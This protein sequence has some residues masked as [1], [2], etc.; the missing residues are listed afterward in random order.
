MFQFATPWVLWALVL[1]PLVI[2]WPRRR[3]AR[4]A[5]RYSSR[6]RAS[7]V[8][9][10]LRSRLLWLVP[11]LRAAGLILLIVAAARPRQGIGEVRTSAEGVAIMFVVDRSW[12]MVEPIEGRGSPMRI[13]VVKE[14][15]KRF[16]QGD[17]QGLDGRSNDL[18]GLVTF[19]KYAQTVCPLVRIHDSLVKLVDSIEL[20][21]P[22][23]MDAGTAIGE[24]LALAAARLKDAEKDL[25]ERNEGDLDPDFTLKSKVIVLLTDGDENVT[26]ITADQAAQLC[27]DWDI[28]VY[29]VGI[30]ERTYRRRR[31]G[32]NLVL[33][34]RIA[35]QTG[36]VARVASDED[37]LTRIYEEIDRLE[38]TR[39]QSKEY[40]SYDERFAPWALA[41]FGA[42]ALQ[43]LLTTTWLGRVP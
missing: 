12:S 21:H 22:Q 5:V 33:L 42:L 20:A 11:T 19:G 26:S 16:I 34:D 23:S 39:I 18:I 14:V 27:S 25:K 9:A 31:G 29:A 36:G 32:L 1:V 4:P 41:G 28:R 43:M 2:W 10:S 37:S 3:R 35:E 38:K 17:G 40:T 30:G 6:L 8:G 13:D 7:G 15:C 24:G